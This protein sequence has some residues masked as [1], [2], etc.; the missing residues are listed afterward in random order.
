[1]QSPASFLR[2]IGLGAVFA[3]VPF[4]VC[5]QDDTDTDWNH[6]GLNLRAGFN[7]KAK[8]SEPS[9]GAAPF[10]IGSDGGPAVNRQYSDGFVNVDSSGNQGG[11]TWNWGYQHASQ[12]SGGDVL[13][14]AGGGSAGG[15]EQ[16]SSDPNL[17]FDFNYVR[18]IGHYDWGQ[19]G[20]KIAAGYTHVQVRDNDPMSV[21]MET[22]TDAYAL[23]GVTPPV[24]P[25]SGSF[26]GPGP[27]LGSEPVSRTVGT[28]EGIISGSHD[29]DAALVDLRLGP[30]VNIPLF[31][32]FS[33][34][35]GG[36]LAV[37]LVDSRFTFTENSITGG[38]VSGGN[39]RAGFVVGAYAEAGFAYRIYHSVSLFTGA[40]FEYLGNFNQSADGRTAQLN[41][42]QT[43][44]FE[45]GAQWQF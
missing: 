33:V 23:N 4:S 37:G 5:A 3:V 38:S 30:S 9:S 27:V 8:F 44:F 15:S 32:R 28:S 36:G 24:A 39:N 41:L 1:M 17:G 6:F 42:G 40:Q 34:Q 22:L 35:A 20:I 10:P 19:L 7:I 31:K 14:H 2:L 18:D 16:T 26:S 43:V 11:Q 29:V 21:K 13:M 45:F 12:V 25:Y